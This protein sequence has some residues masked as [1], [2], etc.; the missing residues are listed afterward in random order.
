M[1]TPPDP[2]VYQIVVTEQWLKIFR[3]VVEYWDWKL[4]DVSM[5]LEHE[6]LPTFVIWP[7]EESERAAT[8]HP[9]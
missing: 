2:P 4:V 1:S 5:V 9:Q 7:K 6:G 3:W 8:P